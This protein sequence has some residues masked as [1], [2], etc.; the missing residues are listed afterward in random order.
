MGRGDEGVLGV[1]AV[2]AVVEIAGEVE[3]MMAIGGEVMVA[4][5]GEMGVTNMQTEGW[6]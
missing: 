6:A 4:T 5:V 3:A 2:E 1:L